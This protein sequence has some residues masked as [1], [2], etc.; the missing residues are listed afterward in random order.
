MKPI[1]VAA[2]AVIIQDGKLLAVKNVDREGFWYILPGGGQEAGEPLPVALQREC[3]EEIGVDVDVHELLYVREYIGRNHE[4][5]D[6]HG[7]AHET[8]LMFACTIRPGQVL[9][10]GTLPDASQVGV[11][12]LDLADLDSYRLYPKVL[13]RVI[14]SA[15]RTGGTYLG[16]VN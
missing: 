11:E 10:N 13:K 5:A 15:K 6:Q 3:R 16:D 8:E 14:A 7:D 2:K 4:F 1:R 12:W 9:G